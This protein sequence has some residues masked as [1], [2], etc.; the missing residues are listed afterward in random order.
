MMRNIGIKGEQWGMIDTQMQ[1]FNDDNKFKF[2]GRL[3]WKNL[4]IPD[5]FWRELQQDL[6]FFNIPINTN[7]PQGTSSFRIWVVISPVIY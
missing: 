3:F 6:A 5:C 1:G 7:P 4:E 2:A